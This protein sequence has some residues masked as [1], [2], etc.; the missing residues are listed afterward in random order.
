LQAS[1]A[2]SAAEQAKLKAAEELEG[3]AAEL[4]S[5][6]AALQHANAE[7]ERLAIET[8]ER[9]DKLAAQQQTIEVCSISS[10]APQDCIGLPH[11]GLPIRSD[12]PLMAFFIRCSSSSGAQ[13]WSSSRPRR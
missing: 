6:L 12:D 5:A 8:A 13:R 4:A 2:A 3:T 10:G 1:A 9:A 7:R 11:I